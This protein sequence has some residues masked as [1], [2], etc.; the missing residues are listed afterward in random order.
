MLAARSS[1]SGGQENDGSGAGVIQ[2]QSGHDRRFY[3]RFH[4]VRPRDVHD[5]ETSALFYSELHRTSYRL[6]REMWRR[7][8]QAAA[9]ACRRR[10][11]RDVDAGKESETRGRVRAAGPPGSAIRCFVS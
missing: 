4:K 9:A 10:R 6:A 7:P 2:E 8:L 3:E 11:R 5:W 1:T